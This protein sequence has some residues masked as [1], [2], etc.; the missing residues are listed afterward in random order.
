MKGDLLISINNKTVSG[1]RHSQVV[2]LLKDVARRETDI[3]IVVCEVNIK[4]I[5][6][7]ININ[8]SINIDIEKMKKNCHFF[9]IEHHFVHGDIGWPYRQSF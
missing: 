7:L 3:K 4:I 5:L 2:E 8:L 9:Q 6:F 1:L